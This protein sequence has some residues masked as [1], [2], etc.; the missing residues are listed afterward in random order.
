[1]S[2]LNINTHHGPKTFEAEEKILGGQVVVAGSKGGVKVAGAAADHVLGVAVVDA[3]PD[4]PSA[5]G[6]L[7]AKPKHTAV[8]YGPAELE[9]EV[10][11]T[12]ALGDKVGSAAGG[13]VTKHSGGDVVG[14]VT[15][16]VGDSR[17]LVRLTV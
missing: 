9:L 14:I 17:A 1:M 8:A 4:T 12:V 11:G 13:K 3:Q 6:V 16:V 7:V 2:G 10:T 5:D 15:R